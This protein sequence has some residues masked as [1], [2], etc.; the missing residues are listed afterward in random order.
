MKKARVLVWVGPAALLVAAV[1]FAGVFPTR[2]Y[3]AQRAAL[4]TAEQKLDVLSEQNKALEDRVELLRSDTEIERLARERYNLVRPGEEAY[5][6]LPPTEAST[7]ST[8]VASRQ[9]ESD[10]D[11]NFVQRA[12]R[13]LTGLF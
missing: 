2:T 13:V 12:W 4:S 7:P 6:V 8:T 5:A 10:D 1:H 9:G 3:L 11:G